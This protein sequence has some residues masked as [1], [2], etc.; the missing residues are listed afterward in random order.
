MRGLLVVALAVAAVGAG[1]A[2][3]G[4][5]APQYR[6]TVLSPS[7]A[8]PSFTL[9][10]QDGSRVTFEPQ[11]DGYSVVTFM[12]THCPDV[13]PV[14]TGNLNQA[15]KTTVARRAGLRVFAVSVD[16][17]GDTPAA[18]RAYARSHRLEPTFRF[19][20]GTKAQLAPIWREFHIAVLP[21]KNGMVSHSLFE[22]LVDP[23]GKERLIYDSQIKTSD[24]VH[25]L[26]QLTK[27][28]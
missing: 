17:Q 28:G 10:D 16:P 6:G 22:I 18:V 25:D 20:R 13:C 9:R 7:P 19:L 1:C 3:S 4:A 23:D 12:Y 15:L 2:A 11:R 5:V 14:V 27:R 26:T 8:A 24:L 21:P